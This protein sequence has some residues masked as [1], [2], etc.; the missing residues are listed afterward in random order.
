MSAPAAE[1]V[2]DLQ[3]WAVPFPLEQRVVH[4]RSFPVLDVAH[5]L[6]EQLCVEELHTYLHI[7]RWHQR[8]ESA[9]IRR[10]ADEVWFGDLYKA[11]RWV[12][13]LAQ[14][15]LILT[16][17]EYLAHLLGLRDAEE[18]E[19]DRQTAAAA[20][21]RDRPS[22]TGDEWFGVWP[23]TPDAVVPPKGQPVVY[24]AWDKNGEIA[25]VGS[26][27]DFPSR[28]RTHAEARKSLTWCRWTAKGCADRR[29]AYTLE[30][31]DI[32]RL[33]PPQNGPGLGERTRGAHLVQS[34]L[35]R[36]KAAGGAA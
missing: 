36:R 12:F 34:A 18:R 11:N 23:V 6:I 16:V 29:A 30:R 31:E 3:A 33:R 14:R 10:L 17:G 27:K 1:P 28:M 2:V 4:G 25:Y 20:K 9:D 24:F 35:R 19:T 7:A 21:L 32:D 26:T 15:G 5:Q 22:Y 13:E 8:G